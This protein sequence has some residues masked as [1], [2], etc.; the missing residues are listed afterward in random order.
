MVT[1][2]GFCGHYKSAT[3]AVP[4]ADVEHLS[5]RTQTIGM[6]CFDDMLLFA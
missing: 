4:E 5:F 1:R 6:F 3:E 2:Q